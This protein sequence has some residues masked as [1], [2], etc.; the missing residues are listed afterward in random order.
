MKEG[1]FNNDRK[2]LCPEA[3]LPSV[4][5]M[6]L[7]LSSASIALPSNVWIPPVKGSALF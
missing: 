5:T 2:T 4:A 1:G 7:N 3:R 6:L